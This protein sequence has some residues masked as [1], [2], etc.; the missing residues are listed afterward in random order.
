MTRPQAG[1]PT[2]I[3]SIF[4][5]VKNKIFSSLRRPDRLWTPRSHPFDVNRGF[6]SGSLATGVVKLATDLPNLI[7]RTVSFLFRHV[8]LRLAQGQ[9]YL[10]LYNIRSLYLD[11]HWHI[12]AP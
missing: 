1:L 3:F 7:L 8:A 6:S 5:S 12:N 10:Y 11:L 2:D 9:F 4:D